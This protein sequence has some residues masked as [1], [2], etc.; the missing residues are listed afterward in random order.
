MATTSATLLVSAACLPKADAKTIHLE[1][2]GSPREHYDD[3]T[4]CFPITAHSSTHTMG[5]ILPH[6]V[7][8]KV[9]TAIP[10]NEFLSILVIGSHNRSASALITE[11]E[12]ANKP[13]NWQRP[14]AT[15]LQTPEGNVLQL[16]VL[17]GQA[18]VEHYAALL[19]TYFATVEFTGRRVPPVHYIP[20]AADA[21][22]SIF[23]DSNLPYLGKIDIAILGYVDK[24]PRCAGPDIWETGVDRETD[25]GELFA[26]KKQTLPD[27]RLVAF[28]GCTACYW[29]DIGGQ[30]IRALKVHNAVQEAVYIGKLGTLNENYIPNSILATGS[31]STFPDG[32]TVEWKSILEEAVKSSSGVVHGVHFTGATSLSETKEWTQQWKRKVDWVDPEIG[33]MAKV[34]LELGIGYGFLHV[35]SDNLSREGLEGLVDERKATI[36]ADRMK[37]LKQADM[38]LD[39]YFGLK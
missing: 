2:Y 3:N 35:V 1:A 31:C 19:S 5:A 25:G 17:P 6:Y 16:N 30:L 13:F 9:H 26:W 38:I 11:N 20:P 36:V 21:C 10:L 14:T 23:A 34:S 32:S 24:L 37:L 7:L 28:I 4:H 22:A 8:P 29:G 15:V 18:Y 39:E 33:H 27:G 12:K